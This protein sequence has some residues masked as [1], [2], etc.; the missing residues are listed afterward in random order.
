M[1]RPVQTNLFDFT[2]NESDKQRIK[3]LDD[4]IKKALK[5]NDYSAA[6]RLTDEQRLLLNKLVS[7]DS[8]KK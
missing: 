4:L 6:K 5:K 2:E 8:D 3:E 1:K 7:G